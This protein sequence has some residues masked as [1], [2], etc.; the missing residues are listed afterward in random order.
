MPLTIY[1]S[2]LA[3]LPY[4]VGKFLALQLTACDPEVVIVNIVSVSTRHPMPPAA[5]NSPNATSSVHR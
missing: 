4:E 5:A 1:F 3:R 2:W